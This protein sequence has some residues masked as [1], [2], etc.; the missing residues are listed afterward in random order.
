MG[1]GRNADQNG[2]G[3]SDGS[4]RPWSNVH[5]KVGVKAPA[6]CRI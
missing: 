4:L 3:L 6:K 1:I 2:P 5:P